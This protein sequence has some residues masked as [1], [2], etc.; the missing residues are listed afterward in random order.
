[1]AGA[2]WNAVFAAVCLIQIWSRFVMILTSVFEGR[3]EL[4]TTEDTE[5]HRG[6]C[7]QTRA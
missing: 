1:M 5:A 7:G 4:L 3:N 6:M 2:R